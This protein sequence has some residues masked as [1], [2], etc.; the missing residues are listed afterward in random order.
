MDIIEYCSPEDLIKREQYYLQGL[1]PDYNILKT[2]GSLL[3][4]KHSKATIEIIRNAKLGK[5]RSHTTKLQIEKGNTQSQSVFVI[6]NITG[7]EREFTSI[8]KAAI[9]VNK[10]PSYISKCIRNVNVYIGENFLIKPINK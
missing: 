7:E 10:H 5:K 8:R 1:K 2:A 3:G 9:Y 4:F 6:N